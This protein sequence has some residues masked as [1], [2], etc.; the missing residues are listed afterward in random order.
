MCVNKRDE[1][2]GMYRRIITY[3]TVILILTAC[4]GISDQRPM[5]ESDEEETQSHSQMTDSEEA[6]EETELLVSSND[7]NASRTLINPMG[8]IVADRVLLP[9]GFERIE[10]TETS[11]ATYLRNTQLK[12]HGTEVLLYDGRLKSNQNV[13][14]AVIDIDVGDRDLQQCA[15]ATMRLWAEYLRS[16]GQ[17]EKIH[18]EFT[19]GFR[20]DY[21]KWMEG[22]RIS[23]D[24]NDVSWVKRQEAS[25]SDET[26][27]SYMQMI[28][29]YAGTL[30]LSNELQSVPIEEM[31]IGDIFVQG[32]S[33]GHAV[34]V[35]DMAVNKTTDEKIFLLAQSYMPAQNIHILI[36]P[37][38]E[39]L[40]PWYVLDDRSDYVTPEWRFTKSD[41]RRY[42]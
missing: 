13:H 8:E 11:F 18:F 28:F 17:E 9:E 38:D 29:A 19:N 12:T 42:E 16:I 1:D 7:Q 23:V 21:S 14:V 26:F 41:L 3:I 15:D 35:M 39:G 24:G 2:D 10:E 30:S 22:Y 32:G 20:V 37:E 4:S 5:I 36:N 34:I 27:M 6:K 31:S 33:P 25:N 40:S